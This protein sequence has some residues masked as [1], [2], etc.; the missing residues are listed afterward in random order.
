MANE[1]FLS[2]ENKMQDNILMIIKDEIKDRS[3]W[4][5]KH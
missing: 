2:G 5:N 4:D 1:D 3:W